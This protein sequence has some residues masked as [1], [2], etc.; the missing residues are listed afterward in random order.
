MTVKRN[1]MD[2]LIEAATLRWQENTIAIQELDRR[3][4]EKLE[5]LTEQIGRL[6][7][8]VNRV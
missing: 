3:L 6:T 4:N 2:A 7:E 1:S 8:N 5:T